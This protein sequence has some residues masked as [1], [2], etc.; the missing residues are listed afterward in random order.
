[1]VLVFM[2][3]YIKNKFMFSRRATHELEDIDKHIEKL[4]KDRKK[5]LTELKHIQREK[6]DIMRA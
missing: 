1:M 2:N 5:K 4:M 3:C 6:S